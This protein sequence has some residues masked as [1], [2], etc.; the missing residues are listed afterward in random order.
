MDCSMDCWNLLQLSEVFRYVTV[1]KND[2]GRP[3][4]LYIQELFLGFT[5]V[6]SQKGQDLA[7]LITKKTE[8]VTDLQKIR[9]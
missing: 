3:S 1:K 2:E 4:S 8:R 7:F 9:G 6:E 5:E